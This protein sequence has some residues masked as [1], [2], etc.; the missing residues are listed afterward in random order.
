MVGGQAEELISAGSLAILA[1]QDA[2]STHQYPEVV[3][4]GEGRAR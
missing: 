1:L 2:S 4:E 3:R